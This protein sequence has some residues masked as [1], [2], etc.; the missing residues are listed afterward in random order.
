VLVEMT[1]VL[2]LLVFL[3]LGMIEM[4]AAWRDQQTI[5]QSSR[6]GARVGSHIGNDNFADREAL[7]AAISVL[8]PEQRANLKYITIFKADANG[9][10]LLPTCLD[11][12]S[13]GLLGSSQNGKCNYYSAAVLTDANLANPAKWNCGAIALDKAYCPTTRGN[14]LSGTGPD[15]IGVHVSL[16]RP[17]FTGFLPG[18]GTILNATSVMQLEP[19]LS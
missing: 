18:D 1:L 14:S 3:V 8:T 2:P 10:P 13:L 15:F 16:D 12:P 9:D 4:G 19:E 11:R 5:T 7:Q 17:W 6:Q